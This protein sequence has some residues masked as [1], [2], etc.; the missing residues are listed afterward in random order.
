MDRTVERSDLGVVDAYLKELGRHLRGPRRT[1]ADLLAEA[2][3]GLI[4][5]TEGYER[6][7]LST[8]EAQRRAVAEFGSMAE[9][10]PGYQ[11]EL[12]VAQSRRTS[13][14]IFVIFVAQCFLWDD[15][16]GVARGVEHGWMIDMVKW[17]G[18]AVMLGALLAL[19]GTARGVRYLGVR[20]ELARATAV[21]GFVVVIAFAAMAVL[22]TAVH[23]ADAE[24][25]GLS[26]LPRAAVFLMLPLGV[27]AASANRCRRAAMTTVP[28]I[29]R[30]A[31]A[32]RP[33]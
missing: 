23:T 17:G 33:R 1:R 28:A 31:V 18:G 25:L 26:G 30:D 15:K 2:R 13:F 10:A 11:A 3:G 14:L 19:A 12:A 32:A 5:T 7:G 21:F 22:L 8:A 6:R 20:R 29:T 24:L 27:I 4:D 16:G 9:V